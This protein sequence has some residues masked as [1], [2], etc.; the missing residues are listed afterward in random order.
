MA[1]QRELQSQGESV[2]GEI[3]HARR[4]LAE[5][6][7]ERTFY[8]RQAARGKI[9]EREFDARMDETEDAR[10]YWQT[11]VVRLTEL[12]DNA[13]SVQ[14][15][16]DYAAELLATLRKRLSQI[17]QPLDELKALPRQKREEILRERQDIVRTL[18]DRVEVYS[19]GQ[20]RLVGVLDGSRAAKFELG[21]RCSPG[22]RR[23]VGRRWSGRAALG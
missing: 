11:E 15:G 19:D 21:N 22:P 18:C 10:R 9:I 17:D 23:R 4:K 5:V 14:S 13:A 7:K 12:R 6:D 16:L 3:A 1:R 8:Q 20:V 2:E